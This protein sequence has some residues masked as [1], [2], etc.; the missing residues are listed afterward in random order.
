MQCVFEVYLCIYFCAFLNIV[1]SGTVMTGWMDP[2]QINYLSGLFQQIL[3]DCKVCQKCTT[4]SKTFT[5]I[6]NILGRVTSAR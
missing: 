5:N 1:M 6:I 3:V 2:E 4:A